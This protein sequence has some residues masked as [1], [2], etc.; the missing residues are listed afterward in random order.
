MDK[1]VVLIVQARMGSI[2]LPGKSLF[3]LA[4]EPLVG[5]LIERVKR[6]KNID[7]IVL[8]IPDT[9][10]NDPLVKLSKDYA[11]S[12]FRGSENDLID[13]YYQA[14]K[15][16]KASIVG[17]LPA[18]NPVPEPNEIDRIIEYHLKSN[19]SFSSNL[20]EVYGNGYPD[21]IGAEMIDFSALETVWKDCINPKFREHV[22]LNF[23]NYNNQKQTDKRFSIGTID[24]PNEFKRPEILLDVNTYD[25]YEFIK[26]IYEYLYNKNP[27]FH[28]TDILDWYDHIYLKNI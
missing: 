14:A 11:I 16:F 13:R 17:R 8:A 20:C 5:R 23:F 22:H 3:D 2:R 7:E 6:C 24:C 26:Q 1:K 12:L 4:G 21:G 27:F 15:Y 9:V 19:H 25:Q 18:D 10:D 28:I